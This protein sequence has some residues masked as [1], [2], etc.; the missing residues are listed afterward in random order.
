[1]EPSSSLFRRMPRKGADRLTPLHR[2]LYARVDTVQMVMEGVSQ[3][4]G[5]CCARVV[6]VSPPKSWWCME[7]R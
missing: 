5:E 4:G 1:M 2:E 6:D 3:V 7:G